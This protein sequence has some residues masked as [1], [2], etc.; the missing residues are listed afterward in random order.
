MKYAKWKGKK[1]YNLYNLYIVW[2]N[3]Y[4]TMKQTW[5]SWELIAIRYLQKHLFKIRDTNFRFWR[6]WEID[7]IAEKDTKVH[8]IEVKYRRNLKYGTPEEAVIPA[9]LYKCQKTMEYYCKKNHI[10]WDNI[11]FD[12]IAIIK[13]KESY[14]ITHYRNISLSSS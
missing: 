12:V 9:K 2:K 5:D 3:I 6:F 10:S 14:K 1:L 11:Q 13:W 8:F 7:I 4:N